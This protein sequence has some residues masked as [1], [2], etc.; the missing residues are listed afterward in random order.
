MKA[1]VAFDA[2]TGAIRHVHYEATLEGEERKVDRGE[3][4][5]A[6]ALGRGEEALDA[7]DLEILEVDPDELHAGRSI[8]IEVFV[9]RERR[10]LA[11]RKR[12]KGR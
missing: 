12:P 4:F 3:V 2:K 1:F 9:D 7:G 5:D 10:T 8:D 11:Q 6:E